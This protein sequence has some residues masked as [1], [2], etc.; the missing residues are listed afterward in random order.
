MEMNPKKQG[1]NY[2]MEVISFIVGQ[3]DDAIR[4][5]HTCKNMNNYKSLEIS[6]T[7]E[8]DLPGRWVLSANT[9]SVG[10]TGLP[11]QC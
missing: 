2:I 8:N 4:S 5:L 10:Y 11:S 1:N 7:G 3:F 6:A 9:G